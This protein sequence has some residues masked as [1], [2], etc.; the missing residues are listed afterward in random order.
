MDKKMSET[1][2]KAREL[3]QDLISSAGNITGFEMMKGYLDNMEL[4]LKDANNTAIPLEAFVSKEDVDDIR[5]YIRGIIDAKIKREAA[6]LS[7]LMPCKA[8]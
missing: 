7:E 8:G 4:A 6:R 5:E 2:E 1:V 3:G